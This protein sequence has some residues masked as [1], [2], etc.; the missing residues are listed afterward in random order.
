MVRRFHALEDT[1]ALEDQQNLGV[2]P[3]IVDRVFLMTYC[4]TGL[5]SL[6]LNDGLD[7]QTGVRLLKAETVDGKLL[8]LDVV[9]MSSYSH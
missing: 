2:S 9:P 5:I 6:L 7:A 3:E 8:L 1:G 4:I